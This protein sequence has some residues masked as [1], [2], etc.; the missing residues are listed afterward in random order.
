MLG[1]DV[2]CHPFLDHLSSI[3]VVALHV[4][5]V[6]E[7]CDPKPFHDFRV[8]LLRAFLIDLFFN[9]LLDLW[10]FEEILVEKIGLAAPLFDRAEGHFK[11]L[12]GDLAGKNIFLR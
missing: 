5:V 2:I 4:N 11:L 8:S 7:D 12:W 3:F 6:A 9:D 1:L 10:A